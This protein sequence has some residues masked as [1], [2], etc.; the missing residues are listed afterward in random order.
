MRG[1]RD[2]VIGTLVLLLAISQTCQAGE[3][4]R[5]VDLRGG[6]QLQSS[7]LAGVT[8]AEISTPG[9]AG[10]N[11]LSTTVP[12]TVLKTMIDHGVYPDPRI[13]LNSFK[14]PDSSDAFNRKHGLARFSH[15]PDQR[16]PWRDP[17]WYRTDFELEPV[18]AGRQ[19]WLQ[20]NGINYRGEVWLNGQKV[21]DR[22][23][24][25]GMFQR[26]RLD[27]SRQVKQGRNVLAVKIFPVDHPGEPETQLEVMG[28]D[29]GFQK[30]IMKDVTEVMTIGYDCMGTVPDRNMGIVQ[31]V[32]LEQTGPVDIRHPF[33]TTILPLPAT[34]RA[35]LHITTE[36]VNGE[37]RAVRGV[38]RGEVEGTGVRFAMDVELQ[39]HQAR[40]VA[41]DP[42][43]V[44]SHPRLWWPVNYGEQ[45][46]YRL[47]LR[48]ETEQGIS[49]E[50]AVSFGVRQVTTE[51]HERDGW[52]GRRIMINGQKIF[53]HGGYVQPEFLL[54][55]D[56]RRIET[57]L[58]YYRD[59]NLNLI[60]F[61]DIPN[62]PDA[63]LDA[64]DRMGILF[65][66]CFYACAWP[67]PNT[68]H[69]QD[70]ELLDRCT[71]DL[72]KRYRNHPSLIMYMVQN[73]ETTSQAVYEM[74]RR[75][76]LALDGTRFWIPSGYFPD[77]RKDVPE[78]TKPDLPAGMNDMGEKTYSWTE[79]ANYFH[80]VRNG[81]NWMF[82]IENGSPS[83]PPISSLTRFLPDL[84]QR[85]ATAPF[86]LT[87]A[88]AHHDAC[89]FY[90][91]YDQA[92]RRLL[93][94]PE[95]VADYCWKAQLLTADQHRA[96]HEAVNHRMWD[97]TSGFTQWKI[98]A[99]WPS[100]EWQ[101]F[102]WYL[103]PMVSLSFI[104]HACE[105]VH[106]QLNI[107]DLKVS[108][109][110]RRL[111]PQ[112]GLRVRARLL[113]LESKLL[114]EKTADSVV[115]ANHYQEVFDVKVPPGLEGG[116]Y[117][118]RLDLAD[119]TGRPLS[120]NLYWLRAEG[121]K[122]YTALNRMASA[123]L[124]P[125]VRIEEHGEET[126]AVV[127]LSNPSD[128]IALLVQLALTDG[129]TGE[130]IL[131]AFWSDNYLGLLPGETREITAKIPQWALSGKTPRLEVGGWNVASDFTCST[132]SVSRWEVK[133][134]EAFDVQAT[135]DRTFLD[136]SRVPL[137]V[138]GETAATKWCWARQKP[139]S[140]RFTIK[141]EKP[142][143]HRIQVGERT[144]TV[145]VK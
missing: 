121:V 112:R 27:V 145:D 118:V 13:G 64:C 45:H 14:I 49:D 113:D 56:A 115:A 69:P 36:L 74:W 44:L 127:K 20:F 59:A 8:G 106:V 131:P 19:V 4:S 144:V 58:R 63:L 1:P 47:K 72:F 17:Y 111:E 54:A 67:K 110:N 40:T 60:Y 114:W 41:I 80:W 42:R 61:E 142:G 32:F 65:G 125:T 87:K 38:L 78:W 26:F 93:G 91:D 134:G 43:P 33:V 130:E 37:P 92:L 29:R 98:N 50:E 75:H 2:C 103:K 62:P 97:V 77:D 51:L 119:E 71:I 132:M 76:N 100:V 46:L 5:R 129:Q 53:C 88:W 117:F 135:V 24:M 11:W 85:S 30:E 122:D 39:A 12:A 6:W 96:M 105:P 15:L 22:K 68:D 16:N 81:R 31:E 108:V 120:T 95:S 141:I 82:Q 55:W 116:V 73:E 133:A 66:N 102:D 52:H 107:P 28:K 25:V 101:I 3:G 128:R 86:P 137:I 124:E 138:D 35:T 23:Q 84:G 18:P 48:F 140:V 79:P 126:W 34:D 99:A 123:K 9:F 89:F 21:S 94:E 90:K 83:V 7:V 57:E 136:G 104:K 139:E 143:P 109:I 70:L 10:K